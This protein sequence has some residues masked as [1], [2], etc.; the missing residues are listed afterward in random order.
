MRTGTYL[1]PCR[2]TSDRTRGARTGGRFP[3]PCRHR[4]RHHRHQRAAA[5]SRGYQGGDITIP[6]ST[7]QVIKVSE[8][9]NLERM[10]KGMDIVTTDGTTLLARTTKPALPK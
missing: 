8:Y 1:P 5:R 10:Y 4:A 3:G 7:G 2:P 6:G 9:P